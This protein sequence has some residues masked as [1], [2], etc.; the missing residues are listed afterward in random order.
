MCVI[1][2]QHYTSLT[3]LIYPHLKIMLWDLNT[4][5]LIETCYIVK[6]NHNVDIDYQICDITDYKLVKKSV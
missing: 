2:P 6:Q 1:G 3:R 4:Q 5:D